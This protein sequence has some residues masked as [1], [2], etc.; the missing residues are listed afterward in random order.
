LELDKAYL[1]SHREKPILTESSQN[2]VH[3]TARL[4]TASGS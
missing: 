2:R 1:C 3:E 4:K